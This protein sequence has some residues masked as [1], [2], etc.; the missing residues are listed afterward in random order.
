MLGLREGVIGFHLT[1][2]KLS[3]VNSRAITDPPKMSLLL[4]AK[5][6][7][8][9][10]IKPRITRVTHTDDLYITLR[11]LHAPDETDV[12]YQ[13]RC[14][15]YVQPEETDVRLNLNRIVSILNIAP[16]Q[17]PYRTPDSIPIDSIFQENFPTHIQVWNCQRYRTDCRQ[18]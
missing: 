9:L 5:S 12:H 1:V 3:P 10:I 6:S 16:R 2:D 18:R 11:A 15:H 14:V 7:P 13:K 4:E 8:A 17:F